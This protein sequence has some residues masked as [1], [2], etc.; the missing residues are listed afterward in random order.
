MQVKSQHLGHDAVQMRR[1]AA[2]RALRH[3]KYRNVAV[4]ASMK[5]TQALVCFRDRYDPVSPGRPYLTM[6]GPV[7]TLTM[8]DASLD[9]SIGDTAMMIRDMSEAINGDGAMPDPRIIGQLDL[10][11]QSIGAELLHITYE[12]DNDQL[13][14]LV[15]KN[16]Y[17]PKFAV[18]HEIM[19]SGLDLPVLM[20]ADVFYMVDAE[21][22]M[23]KISG[24]YIG[25]PGVTQTLD[26]S[27]GY[28][29]AQFFDAV[30]T[31]D[32]MQAPPAPD[33]AM[34]PLNKEAAAEYAKQLDKL[35]EST[36]SAERSLDRTAQMSD[37]LERDF[38]NVVSD[39]VYQS[40]Q[41]SE[42]TLQDLD[43]VRDARHAEPEHMAQHA[44]P[45]QQSVQQPVQR[46]I[47]QPTPVASVPSVSSEPSS[48]AGANAMQPP[49]MTYQPVQPAQPTQ[50]TQPTQ[51]AQTTQTAPTSVSPM[52]ATA[53]S[54]MTYQPVA[55]VPPALS[56]SPVDEQP[57]MSMPPLSQRPV[58]TAQPVVQN[59]PP[60]P[61]PS[62]SGVQQHVGQPAP[63][64]TTDTKQTN[65]QKKQALMKSV[66]RVIAAV[67]PDRIQLESK[68]ELMAD[69][70]RIVEQPDE[71]DISMLEDAAAQMNDPSI[72]AVASNVKAT[73]A[74]NQ[75]R[76]KM[77]ATG[78]FQQVSNLH[79]PDTS[80]VNETDLQSSMQY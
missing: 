14:T 61:S 75:Q 66:Y 65:A 34:G 53:P 2:N 33:Y 67:A 79:L 43:D 47:S 41:Q 48:F 76:A 55:S 77:P 68:D 58:Q 15:S 56:V 52:P 64:T 26:T 50:T 63:Q 20:D 45:A 62:A 4:L 3:M 11:E 18:P 5:P 38:V 37:Q 7:S 8:A 22:G 24:L 1:D 74:L 42:T 57:T 35:R 46:A 12:F 69:V 40:D 32:Y 23:D 59:I 70:M 19:D 13:A 9:P 72:L 27:C 17:S 73:Y 10:S 31:P 16:L 39:A 6:S 60:A 29:L 44:A 71:D 80:K 21:P 28:D 25:M 78:A 30:P 36:I 51:T 49:V 54:V